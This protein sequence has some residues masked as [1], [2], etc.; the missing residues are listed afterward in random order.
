MEGT[1]V[2]GPWRLRSLMTPRTQTIAS[3]FSVA[4]AAMLLGA[5]VTTQLQRPQAAEARPP[6]AALAPAQEGASPPSGPV[7]LDTFRD[8]ARRETAGVVNVNTSKVV[9][10]QRFRD[11]FGDDMMERFFGPGDRG[12]LEKQTQRNLGSGF[13]IDKDG[14]ILTNRH[15]VEGAEQALHHVVSEEVAEA[16]AIGNPF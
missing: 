16:L 11:F 4:M 10:R 13:V 14:Y 12:G 9:N 5:L 15:V 8:I 1:P 7:T 2:E 3:F 6:R